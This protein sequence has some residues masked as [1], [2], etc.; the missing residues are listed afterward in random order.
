MIDPN[1]PVFCKIQPKDGCH[2]GTFYEVGKEYGLDSKPKIGS[3]GFHC[4][5]N[6]LFCFSLCG[7]KKTH[8]YF[9]VQ[10]GT[11]VDECNDEAIFCSD[12]M[13]VIEE[14]NFEKVI[15]SITK[16]MCL[17][18]VSKKGKTLEY[19]PENMKTLEVCSAALLKDGCS[20]KHVPENMMTQEMCLA[21]VLGNEYAIKY[22]PENMMTPEMCLK[23]VL[24]DGSLLQWVP[25]NMKTQ[26]IC[27]AALSNDWCN[28]FEI[29]PK[30]MMTQAMCFE[31]VLIKGYM[32]EYVP[33]NMKT[34]GMCLRA[35][36]EYSRMLDFV[37]ENMKKKVI[38]MI[39]V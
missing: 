20:L 4:C 27:F 16:K 23:A 39:D 33:E 6:F 25:D 22:V 26:E 9:K 15:K 14:W 7:N 32:L 37:P 34:F 8:R 5:P 29:I 10:L 36:S 19:V 13:R 18:S 31:A 24:M 28:T 30:S 35:A 17:E 3:N 1:S 2:G 21:A 11:K 12:E 38:D